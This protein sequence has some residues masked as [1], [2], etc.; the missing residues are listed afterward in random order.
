[1]SSYPKVV[2]FVPTY[3]AEGF[4]LKTLTALANQTYPNFEIIIC[5]DCS[6]DKTAAICE[7][8][9]KT[10]KRFRLVRNP[11]NLGWFASSQKLWVEAAQISKYCFTNPHDDL[12]Y[13]EFI[14]NLVKLLEQSPSASL[15][16]PGMENEYQDMTINSFYDNVSGVESTVER[17]FRIVKK[18]Q[19][20]WWAAY[21]GLHRSEI[22]QKVFPIKKL[23]FGEKEFSLDL[24][25]MLKMTCYGPFVTSDQILFKKVYL[26]S[27]VSS[28]WAHDSKNRAALWVA[29]FREI[30][31]S[32]LSPSEKRT[33]RNRLRALLFSRIAA[34]F[35]LSK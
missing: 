14:D 27:S 28:K 32:P 26:K 9:C 11:K 10:D 29:I 30:R 15:A 1:M 31:N 6:P 5:D 35:S 18:D 2:G 25:L 7:E 8:F 21:H 19:H 34:R 16:V 23:P 3:K 13:P 17:C 20:H 4:V 24:I 12:L 22:V 33:L